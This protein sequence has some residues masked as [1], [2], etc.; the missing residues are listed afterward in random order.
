MLNAAL[1]DPVN[2]PV[3]VLNTNPTGS[4][5]GLIEYVYAPRPPEP[6]TG[7]VSTVSPAV[8]VKGL[9][10]ADADKLGGTTSLT[11]IT[12]VAVFF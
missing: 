11:I 7:T 2:E 5:V 8:I 12:I 4:V 6:V 3:T 10:V 1:V 9:T